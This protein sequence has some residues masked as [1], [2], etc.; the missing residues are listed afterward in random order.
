MNSPPAGSSC[1]E[2]C[3]YEVKDGIKI[4]NKIWEK[5]FKNRDDTEERLRNLR[6][7]MLSLCLQ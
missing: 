3:V 5:R 2:G 4:G 6:V 1:G 7:K